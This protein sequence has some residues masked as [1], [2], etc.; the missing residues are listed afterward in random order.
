MDEKELDE[1]LK[2]IIKDKGG[3]KDQ[4]NQLMDYIAFHETGPGQRMDPEARQ[5]TKGGKKDGFGRGLFMFEAGEGKGG[6]LAVNRT[7]NYLEKHNI[8]GP[9]SRVPKWL[10]ELWTDKK[11]VDVSSLSADKQ[12]ML[13]LG[14]HSENPTSNFS[15]IWSGNQSIQDF[16]INNHWGGK[17]NSTDKEVAAKLDL[18]NKS[19]KAKNIGDSLLNQRNELKT[20]QGTAP[21]LSEKNDLKEFDYKLDFLKD[22]FGQQ[23]SS[24]VERSVI[25]PTEEIE[26]NTGKAKFDKLK[27]WWPSEGVQAKD[28]RETRDPFNI[29]GFDNWIAKQIPKR[30]FLGGTKENTDN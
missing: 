2:L 4:Y 27:Y 24:L 3:T 22:I 18:F 15:D 5:I 25:P 10:R 9:S 16:W 14:Y 17:G 23:T 30:K 8:P 26:K 21:W 7:V 12:K 6:N 11:S 13:F 29:I 19:M 28:T 20:K 1:L